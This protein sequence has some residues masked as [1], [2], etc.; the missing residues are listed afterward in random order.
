MCGGVFLLIYVHTYV[1]TH[2]CRYKKEHEVMKEDNSK[3]KEELSGYRKYNKELQKSSDKMQVTLDSLM[4]YKEQH[5]QLQEANESLKQETIS[6]QDQFESIL[7]EKQDLEVQNFET[8]QALNEEREA[9]DVLVTRLRDV[10]LKSPTSPSWA[11]EKKKV[12]FS[13]S[14]RGSILKEERSLNSTGVSELSSPVANGMTHPHSTPS[15][16]K[17]LV[18]EV[19]LSLQ[20][21]LQQHEDSIMELPSS[22]SSSSS[23]SAELEQLRRKNKEG[24]EM[25]TA[26]QAEKQ[27]LEERLT[28]SAKQH[29]EELERVKLE[30][31]KSV[32]EQDHTTKTAQE[33]IAMK[34]ELLNQLRD[35]LTTSSARKVSLEIEVEGLKDEM[36]RLRKSTSSELHKLQSE[37]TQEQNT[38]AELL[39]RVDMLQEQVNSSSAVI[40]NLE[41]IL[42]NS[43]AEL[44]TMG[45]GLRNLHK[46]VQTLSTADRAKNESQETSPPIPSP[47]DVNLPGVQKSD[48]G[49][50]PN[51]AVYSLK[52]SQVKS[53]VHI[54]KETNSLL[55][56]VQLHEQLRSIR[57][58]LEKFTRT[59][60]Q[61]SLAH[62]AKHMETAE[63]KVPPIGGGVAG[64]GSGGKNATE[65]EAAIGKWKSKLAHKVEEVSNL[66]AIMKARATTADVAISSLKSKLEGQART[67]QTELTRLKYQVK[68]IVVII[69]TRQN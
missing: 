35:Q 33:D 25:A 56:V 46:T 36:D 4:R 26:L 65:L 16:T 61:R 17:D 63:N 8:V 51:R 43:C 68:S 44:S 9:K 5:A 66:R 48:D 47:V 18:N 42:F 7:V 30:Y 21:E 3:L 40:E 12:S 54:H 19:V 59:M 23:N 62:S 15:A 31:C 32:S 49:S 45:E 58:P 14:D 27:V 13:F 60:L 2:S 53:P 57:S 24:D 52:L 1:H 41:R 6:L 37:C 29:A 10:T 69:I 28:L 64:G 67:Y 38:N 22:S 34:E 20:T 55:A 11:D 50:E 39:N